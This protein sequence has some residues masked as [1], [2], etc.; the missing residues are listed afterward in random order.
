ME[1]VW[2]QPFVFKQKTLPPQVIN[3]VDKEE[4][5]T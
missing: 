1:P 3:K 2:L 5:H 4:H